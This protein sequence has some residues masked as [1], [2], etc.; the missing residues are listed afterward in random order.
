MARLLLTGFIIILI[1][2][3]T[4]A[5]SSSSSSSSAAIST[6]SS[7]SSVNHNVAIRSRREEVICGSIDIRNTVKMF[8]KLENYTV[9][10]GHLQ[11]LLIENATPSDYHNL[12]FPHLVEITDYLFSWRAN[13]LTS[14]GRLFPNLSVIRGRKLFY[15]YA[16]AAYE[17][18]NLQEIALTNLAV[19]ERGSVRLEKNPQLC[20]ADTIDWDKITLGSKIYSTSSPTSQR[21]SSNMIRENKPSKECGHCPAKGCDAITNPGSTSDHIKLCWNSDSCQKTCHANCT[22]AG[23]YCFG[24]RADQCCHENCLGGC[25]G[26]KKSNCTSCKGFRDHSTSESW[27]S[28][29]KS[30]SGGNSWLIVSIYFTTLDLRH[31]TLV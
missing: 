31:A 23:N 21:T 1:S 27:C 22:S 13:G 20:F 9:I 24:P 16:L 18:N 28:N 14:L 6:L 12:S 25:Y 26:P 3:L 5:A 17:M 15:E 11:I 19:I 7:G 2:I 10:E 4:S 30:C 8:S 29:L